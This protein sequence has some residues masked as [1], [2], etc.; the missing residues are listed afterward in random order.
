MNRLA[1]IGLA[2]L[3]AYIRLNGKDEYYNKLMEAGILTENLL[4]FA[5]SGNPEKRAISG[6]DE[7]TRRIL[8]LLEL[9]DDNEIAVTSFDL[10]CAVFF[11]PLLNKVLYEMGLSQKG[12]SMETAA[13]ICGL[14]LLDLDT[15]VMMQDAYD[16]I[17]LFL[18]AGEHVAN[19]IREGFELDY[20]LVTW[21]AGSSAL[22]QSLT[23]ICKMNYPSDNIQSV[24]AYQD[25]FKTFSDGIASNIELRKQTPT[26]IISGEP[27][28]GRF[29]LARTIANR[30]DMP[31]LSLN[32]AVFDNTTE[33]REFI[34]ALMRECL[35]TNG[36]LCIKNL[37]PEEDSQMDDILADLNSIIT[38]YRLF[39]NRPIIITTDTKVKLLPY[40][41]NVCFFEF[42][43]ITR[44]ESYGLWSGFCNENNLSIDVEEVSSKMLL[45]PGQVK[46]VTDYLINLIASGT[47]ASDITDSMLCRIC[48]RIID[49]GRY[50]NIKR[51]HSNYS[52]KD[53]QI[54]IENMRILKEI[55]NQVTFRRKVYDEWNMGEKYAYGRSISLLLAGPPGTGKTMAVHALANELGLELYKADL[56]QIV[57]KYI[58]ETQ[59]RLEQIF[60]QAEKSHMILFFDEADSL[61]GKRSETKD[62]HDKYSNSEIAFILQRIEEFDGIVVMATNFIQNIDNAFMRRIRYVIYFEMP[63]AA[64]RRKIWEGAFHKNVPK[65]DDI[66]FSFLAENFEIS[67]GNIKN[68]VLNAVFAAASSN[69]PVSMKH[70]IRAIY[71]ENHKGN[72]PTF[73]D[74][75]GAYATYLENWDS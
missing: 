11:N 22:D 69:E 12:V 67:G 40:L 50:E 47:P 5:L 52:L 10:C 68:I 66:N 13:K 17:S 75:Y 63:D 74:D 38:K 18:I 21:V 73:T 36:I 29:T 37:H 9:C 20:R 4:S 57:D 25:K 8:N 33:K 55:V 65:S 15:I 30:L 71:R 51:I 46:K 72:K 45:K 64:T 43:R 3:T 53:L 58:G 62:S 31:I 35:L 60:E 23:S 1:E 59:K 24:Y 49:D 28:S 16:K 6:S 2:K 42:E 19:S 44:E 27:D 39:C 14:D 26:V 41:D 34:I 61:F 56:S 48:Y 54:R 7:R 70:I 32:Y